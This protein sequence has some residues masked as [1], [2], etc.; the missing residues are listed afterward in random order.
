[1]DKQEIYPTAASEALSSLASR[2]S[3]EA[4]ESAQG[5]IKKVSKSFS[6]KRVKTEI[7]PTIFDVLPREVIIG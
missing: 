2:P 3:V 1:M 5:K 4:A 6:R 7:K